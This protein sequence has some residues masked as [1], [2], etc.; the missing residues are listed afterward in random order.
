M[1]LKLNTGD[2]AVY[3]WDGTCREIALGASKRCFNVLR[4][5]NNCKFGLGLQNFAKANL[6][7]STEN[8]QTFA[9]LLLFGTNF[10]LFANFTLHSG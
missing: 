7:F 6:T 5:C 9:K 2:I 4:F 8:L 1:L 10:Q 3:E